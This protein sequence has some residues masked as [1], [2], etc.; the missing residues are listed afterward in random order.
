M[1]ADLAAPVTR[2]SPTDWDACMASD[3]K[4]LYLGARARCRDRRWRRA[5]VAIASTAALRS[6]PDHAAYCC[7]AGLAHLTRSIAVDYGGHG[8]RA[9]CICP[10]AVE[11]GCWSGCTRSAPRGLGAR[12]SRRPRAAQAH[13]KSRGIANLACFLASDE[14]STWRAR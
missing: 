9:N 1:G 5:I 10:G 6:I 4:H 8:V 11:T 7:Q 14:A 2:T 12:A 3:L 13:G